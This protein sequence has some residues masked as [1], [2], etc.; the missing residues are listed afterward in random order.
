MI[1][2]CGT[3]SNIKVLNNLIVIF[4]YV[5]TKSMYNVKFLNCIRHVTQKYSEFQQ[6][7]IKK[8]YNY[9]YRCDTFMY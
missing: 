6:F 1:I 2:K 8:K 3:D 4:K 9:R 5:N 7:I